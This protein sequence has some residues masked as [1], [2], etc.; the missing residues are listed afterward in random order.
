MKPRNKA[1]QISFLYKWNL[2]SLFLSVSLGLF[3]T[4]RVIYSGAIRKTKK[5]L[6]TGAA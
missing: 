2:Y 1:N 3:Q 5:L 4:Q 6:S